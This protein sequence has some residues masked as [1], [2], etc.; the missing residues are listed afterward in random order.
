MTRWWVYFCRIFLVSSS[1]LKEFIR[2]SGTSA[3][4]VLFKCCARER[5]REKKRERERERRRGKE[6]ERRR[7]RERRKEG[8][9]KKNERRGI[10]EKR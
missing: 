10:D 1:V 7:E 5:E 6:R 3:L 8:Q 2:T 9:S 4:Y